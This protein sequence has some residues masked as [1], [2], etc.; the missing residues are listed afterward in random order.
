VYKKI[1]VP[2]DS[3]KPSD[4]ALESAIML[5]KL[6]KDSE[7]VIL[8][9][10]HE[11]S[12]PPFFSSTLPEGETVK[13]HLKELYHSVKNDAQKMLDRKKASYHGT[14]LKIQTF[15]T[16]GDPI[17]K[18]IKFIKENKID[19]VIIGTTGLSGLSKIKVFGSVARNVSEKSP[20]PILL[21]H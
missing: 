1:L 2:Y 19:L 10:I 12:L 6:S 14:G 7:I 18:I 9:V 13:E 16:M 8:N 3:S 21:V 5:A 15:V 4:R 20:C 17:E 11:V